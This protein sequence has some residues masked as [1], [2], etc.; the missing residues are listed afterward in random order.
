MLFAIW[1]GH[2]DIVK[3]LLDGGANPEKDSQYEVPLFAAI[4]YNRVGAVQFLPQKTFHTLLY[5]KE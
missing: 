3:L 4:T 1:R 5:S 2:D